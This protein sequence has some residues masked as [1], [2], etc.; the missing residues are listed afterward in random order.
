MMG[1]E[2]EEKSC[3]RSDRMGAVGFKTLKINHYVYETL[4]QLL[5]F[6]GIQFQYKYETWLPED[7][8]ASQ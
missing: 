4:M 3:E 5:S 1:R 7:T 6:Y 8:P 2:L